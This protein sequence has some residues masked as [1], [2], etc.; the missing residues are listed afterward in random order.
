[1]R[2]FCC[3]SYCYRIRWSDASFGNQYG[4]L[5][6]CVQVSTESLA[7]ERNKVGTWEARVGRLGTTSHCV[8]LR[9]LSEVVLSF[10]ADADFNRRVNQ[11][12]NTPFCWFDVKYLERVHLDKKS[13]QNAFLIDSVPEG[14]C[15]GREDV[16]ASV[17]CF[18]NVP[19]CHQVFFPPLPLIFLVLEWD[20]SSG[21]Y[22]RYCC[23]LLWVKPPCKGPFP[24]LEPLQFVAL[25]SFSCWQSVQ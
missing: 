19:V 5:V 23:C 13:T 7:A 18:L 10:K 15:D 14:F 24:Y 16:D 9:M 3:R 17:P 8:E 21:R 22:W 11:T 25:E 4:F 6:F 12:R 1:M 20:N 2:R